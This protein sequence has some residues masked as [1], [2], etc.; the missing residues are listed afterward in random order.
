MDSEIL[1]ANVM[2]CRRIELY[3]RWDEE[4]GESERAAFE[5]LVRER[6]KGCPVAYLVGMREFFC[7]E[8]EVDRSVLIPRPE[9]EHIVLSA[10]AFAAQQ[11]VSTFL[12]VGTGSGV[13]A[14]TLAAELP[15]ARGWALDVSAA[16]L[17]VAAKNA[18]RHDIADRL[19]FHESDLFANLPSDIAFDLV[20]SNPPYVPTGKIN[21]LPI[22]VRGYEPLASLDGGPDGLAIVRR[23]LR[24]SPAHMR[25]NG[26]LLIEMSPEQ[27]SDVYV[28]AAAE[29]SWEPL[30]VVKDLARQPRVAV[31]ARRPS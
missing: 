20:V 4:V 30:P 24:E 17:A 19:T 29:K 23:L 8:F 22:D 2:R 15:Q 21:E 27:H 10:L 6:A 9:T 3:V 28:I 31:F 16:A 5:P 14:V 18:R 11:P 7:R 26:R 1:L 12:D 25:S 13:L